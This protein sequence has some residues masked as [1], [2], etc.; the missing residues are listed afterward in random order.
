M[1]EE[2]EQ[3]VRRHLATAVMSKPFGPL[4]PSIFPTTSVAADIQMITQG[5]QKARAIEATT[6]RANENRVLSQLAA[7]MSKRALSSDSEL[8]II[9]TLRR[10]PELCDKVPADP[11]HM[12]FLL[13]SC[14]GIFECLV[15][16]VDGADKRNAMVQGAL[17]SPL[18]VAKHNALINSVIAHASEL[19]AETLLRYLDVVEATCRVVQKAETRVHNVRSLCKL[20]YIA[21]NLNNALAE[22]VFIQLS[23]FCLSFLKVKEAADLYKRLAE[24]RPQATS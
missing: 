11:A 21:I 8:D 23:S 17:A 1:D 13:A 6:K 9:R 10:Q 2:T 15:S 18:S 12:Q 19:T 4:P 24:L 3:A 5:M 22:Q 16:S 20:F 7:A 14:P